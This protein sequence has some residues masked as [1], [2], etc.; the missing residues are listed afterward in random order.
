MQASVLLGRAPMPVDE[1][2][3]GL[4]PSPA[5]LERQLFGDP[6]LAAEA[7]KTAVRGR[8]VVSRRKFLLSPQGQPVA[9]SVLDAVTPGARKLLVDPPI[10]FSWIKLGDLMDLDRE[11]VRHAWGGASMM[12]TFGEEIASTDVP[13]IYNF[14]MRGATPE[15][16]AKKMDFAFRSYARPGGLEVLKVGSR[17]GVGRLV[18]PP[19]PYYLCAEGMRGWMR[20]M[21][22]MADFRNVAV[23]HTECRHRGDADCTWKVSWSTVQSEV[24]GP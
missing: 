16:I 12:R 11:I 19:L 17:T 6:E 4:R 23:L 8:V 9:Q 3:S 21:L 7:R 2:V 22:K 14:L 24:P 13:R 5:T 10:A 1:P 15:R 18:G 20:A